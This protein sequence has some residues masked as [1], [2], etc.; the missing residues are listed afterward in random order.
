MNL[1]P[2]FLGRF[3]EKLR[4]GPIPDRPSVSRWPCW[5]WFGA[6]DRYGYGVVRLGDKMVKAHRVMYVAANGPIPR[7][8][9]IDHLCR[10]RACVQPRHLQAVSLQENLRRGRV[11]RGK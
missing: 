5:L 9:V 3:R 11:D 2:V 4:L 8:L 1:D 7:G 10:N 6:R